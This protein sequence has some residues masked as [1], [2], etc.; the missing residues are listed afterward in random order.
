MWAGSNL[1]DIRSRRGDPILLHH[2][3]DVFPLTWLSHETLNLMSDSVE[4]QKSSARFGDSCRGDRHRTG[5][6]VRYLRTFAI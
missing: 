3:N 4:V 5:V 6:G 2:A 1:L